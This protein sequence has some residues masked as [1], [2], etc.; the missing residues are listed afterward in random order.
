MAKKKTGELSP[1]TSGELMAFAAATYAEDKKAEDIIIMDMRGISPVTDYYVLCTAT[2]M[3]HLRAVRNE[4]R[5]RFWEEQTLKPVAA[6]ENFESLWIILHYGD[7][8]V[9]IFH[10]DRREFYALE[11]LW[12]DAPVVEWPLEKPEVKKKAATKKAAAKAV[13]EEDEDEGEDEEETPAK[14]KAKAKKAAKK[15]ASPAKKAVKKVA[16]KAVAKKVAPKKN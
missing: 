9:H 2:S 3:P 4:L 1:I 5:E 11:D 16:K 10:K 13:V 12:G 6:D 15:A 7:V 14:P 8:M